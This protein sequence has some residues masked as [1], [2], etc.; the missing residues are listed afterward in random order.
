MRSTTQL[1]AILNFSVR[2]LADGTVECLPGVF[3]NE[4]A[5]KRYLGNANYAYLRLDAKHTRQIGNGWSLFGRVGGQIASGPLI[6]NEQFSAGGV[7]TVRGYTESAASGDDG[8]IGGLELRTPSLARRASER[9][10]DLTLYA[11]AEGASLNIREPLAGQTDRFYLLAA[12]LGLRFKGWSGVSGSLDLAYP[13]EDAGQVEAGDG[14]V[15]FRL[16]YEW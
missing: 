12:G 9:L 10:D 8:L 3:L 14:R 6:S 11:F 13:F 4:F 2:G 16:G 1:A 5:C 7:D 15:H